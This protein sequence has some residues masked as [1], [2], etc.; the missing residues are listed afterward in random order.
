MYIVKIGRIGI[1]YR[2]AC[3]D[4]GIEV[5]I[6]YQEYYKNVPFYNR[7]FKNLYGKYGTGRTWRGA[8]DPT[9]FFQPYEIVELLIAFTCREMY[10]KDG[11]IVNVN[12]DKSRPFNPKED[13]IVPKFPIEKAKKIKIPGFRTADQVEKFENFK[14]LF[15]KIKMTGGKRRSSKNRKKGTKRR[16]TRKTKHKK[17]RRT[18]TL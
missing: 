11:L 17:R 3:G 9:F 10:K 6:D 5:K 12:P 14:P 4:E 7:F 18:R 1:Q 8:T 15:R 13:A 16:T 2:K